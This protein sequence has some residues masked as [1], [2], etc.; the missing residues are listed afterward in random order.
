MFIGL[1]GG[2]GESLAFLSPSSNFRCSTCGFFC[3]A[4]ICSLNSSSRRAAAPLSEDSASLRPSPDR[5]R[6]GAS[7][8]TTASSAGS[9]VSRPLQHGHVTVNVATA[10]K[11]Q[12]TAP[13]GRPKPGAPP[14]S[15]SEGEVLVADGFVA[16]ESLRGPLVPDVAFFEHVHAVGEVEAEVHVLLGQEDREPFGSE[17]PDLLLE[18]L[19]DERRQ[20]LGWL[21]EQEQL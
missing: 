16:A 4:L 5:C 21:V 19:D 3:S 9:M 7:W 15:T 17:P 8:A 12:K 11:Y 14:L 2:S 20:A 6:G 10:S 13:R 18:V 1:S